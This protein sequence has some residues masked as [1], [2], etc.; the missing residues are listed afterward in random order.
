MHFAVGL[1]A[2]APRDAAARRAGDH[3]ALAQQGAA[4]GLANLVHRTIEQ[5][6]EGFIRLEAFALVNR[7]LARRGAAG[8][9]AARQQGC[10]TGAQSAQC[11]S[12]NSM[13]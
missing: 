1:E 4:C 13:R 11:E 10:C 6:R 7:G 12:E 2:F 5:A 9:A 3:I 8:D